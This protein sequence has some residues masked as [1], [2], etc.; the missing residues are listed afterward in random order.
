[1]PRRSREILEGAFLTLA[2]ELGAEAVR[3]LGSP[4]TVPLLFEGWRTTP[5]GPR[6]LQ[7][8]DELAAL[9]QPALVADRQGVVASSDRPV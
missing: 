2:S 3:I 8:A 7:I 4:Q 5:K 1:L 6:R 9:P